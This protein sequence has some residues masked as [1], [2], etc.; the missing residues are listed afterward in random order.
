MQR[1]GILSSNQRVASSNLAGCTNKIK[2]GERDVRLFFWPLAYYR[3]KISP[4]A[5]DRS[6]IFLAGKFDIGGAGIG[7][8]LTTQ[9]Y[10]AAGYS[11]TKHFA[12]LGGYRWLQVDYDDDEGFLFDTQMNGIMIGAKFSW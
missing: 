9:L 2:K 4:A 7:A 1:V 10:G 5:Y 3:P 12:L 11:F 8:D 6:N